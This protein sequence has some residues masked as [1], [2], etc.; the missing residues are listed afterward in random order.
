MTKRS[1][2][3]YQKLQQELETI[4][5]NLQ[6][7]DIDVDHAMQQYARGLEIVKQLE[8]YLKTAE[9]TVTELKAKFSQDT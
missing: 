3:D 4:L 9:N 8:T 1:E 6:R 2:L 5:D 7:D